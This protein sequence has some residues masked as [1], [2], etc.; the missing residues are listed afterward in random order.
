MRTKGHAL[1][2]SAYVLA[3]EV[4]ACARACNYQCRTQRARAVKAH[5]GQPTP[6]ALL[7]LLRP[8]IRLQILLQD[9]Q[10]S[11]CG[12]FVV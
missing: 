1:R 4:R 10:G 6:A 2:C 11:S 8:G 3:C 5:G 7:M 9:S 12:A